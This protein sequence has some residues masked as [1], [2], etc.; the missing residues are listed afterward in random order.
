MVS[1]AKAMNGQV[2]VYTANGLQDTTVVLSEIGSPVA[3]GSNYGLSSS[4]EGYTIRQILKKAKEQGLDSTGVEGFEIARA[5][6]SKG[7]MSVNSTEAN[8]DAGTPPFFYENEGS[9]H[10][11]M[12]KKN[13]PGFFDDEFASSIPIISFARDSGITVD[14]NAD[15]LSVDV[16]DPVRFQ[17]TPG[18]LKAGETVTYSWD[19]RD[20]TMKNGSSSLPHTFKKKGTY[21]VL[22]TVTGSSGRRD[23]A[24]KK[25]QVGPAPKPKNEDKNKEK[26][27]PPADDGTGGYDGYSYPGGTGGYG[28]YPGG[29]GDSPGPASPTP[30]APKPEKQYEPPVDDGLV[31]VS[32]ELVSSSSPA[33]TMSPGEAAAHPPPVAVTPASDGFKI[34]S[35]TWTVL[36]LLALL[37]LGLLAERRGSK[38]T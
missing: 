29:T 31:E 10:F 17:A 7:S 38:L 26:E 22:V 21:Y 13:S 2:K 18:N 3:R 16:G 1:P 28:G 6:L 33:P 12:K 23:T 9:T 30:P 5:K 32:G 25:I 24:S 20:G 8:S 11:V 19:F 37:G 27:D 14:L 4:I 36:G 15:P 35:E 34:S